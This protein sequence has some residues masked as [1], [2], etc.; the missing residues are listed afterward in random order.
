MD[1]LD[2]RQAIM[3]RDV[4]LVAI[5][6]TSLLNGMHFSPYL[7]PV[8]ILLRPFLAGTP[9]GAPLVFLYLASMFTSVM[10]LLI[11]G[12]PA[13]I[14]EHIKGEKD[15]TATSLGIWLGALLLITLPSI[16]AMG[17]RS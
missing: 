8:S 2:D 13:A 10:T 11:G 9:L 3:Q 15:S 5:A 6:G 17:G 4:L 14:Y 7:D 1:N 12:I 16:M